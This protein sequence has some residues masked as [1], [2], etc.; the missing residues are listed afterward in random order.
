MKVVFIAND[1][2]I[3]RFDIKQMI[4]HLLGIATRH[5]KTQSTDKIKFL[6]LLYNPKQLEIT[7]ENIKQK[8]FEIYD[9]EIKECENI[10]FKS[11]F[12]VILTYLHTRIESDLNIDRCANSFSFE[13]CDQN[14]YLN[15]ILKE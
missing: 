1:L 11:L 7:N 13:H 9:T 3:T 2:E 5:L 14:N 15:A 6:Y 12:K 4:S 10:P 8:I